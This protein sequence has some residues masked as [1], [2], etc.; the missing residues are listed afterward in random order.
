[1]RKLAE[2]RSLS[3][4]DA[5]L[6]VRDLHQGTSRSL[7]L[8]FETM[9][10]I[11]LSPRLAEPACSFS[12][13]IADA[14]PESTV[15][16]SV[17]REENARVTLFSFAAGQELT[18]HTNRCRALVQILSGSCDFFYNDAWQRLEAGTLLHLPPDHLHAVRAPE[19][20]K[21][22]LPLCAE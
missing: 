12:L 9:S 20:F 22:L 15:S 21:M 16:K 4:A 14:D 11:V 3:V 18:P 17:L 19:A 10:K 8:L 1:M 2:L 5:R 13:A 7:A 6:P